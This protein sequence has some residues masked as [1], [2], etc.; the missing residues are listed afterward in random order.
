VPVREALA[1]RYPAGAAL[2]A[3]FDEGRVT[4][5]RD[6]VASQGL[7]RG[8][9]EATIA[10]ALMATGLVE[11]VYTAS[12]LAGP[13]AADDP[14][15]SFFQASFFPGRSAD[16]VTLLKQYTYMDERYLGGTGHGTPYEY[17]RHVP[18]A[19]MGPAIR[20]GRDEADAGPEDIAPTL[21]QIL[22]LDYRLD[23]GQ[24]VL[25][26]ALEPSTAPVR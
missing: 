21:A 1:A 25:R 8:A 10:D 17:D 9:V 5:D 18:V 24:R 26:E 7:E 14:Y 22:G 12:K 2:I 13:P 19:F 4:L 15:A 23:P 3:D 6:A 11:R 16:V 20:P